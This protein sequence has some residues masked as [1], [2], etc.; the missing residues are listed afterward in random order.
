MSAAAVAGP[1]GPPTLSASVRGLL[2]AL[3]CGDDAMLLRARTRHGVG[4][5]TLRITLPPGVAWIP[6]PL[7]E[8]LEEDRWSITVPIATAE[9]P[10][11]VAA[12]V[13]IIDRPPVYLDG[14]WVFD[15][16]G[17]AAALRVLA[18]FLEPSVLI[19][20][21]GAGVAVWML[22]EPISAR[23]VRVLQLH[24]DVARVTGATALPEGAS[25]EDLAVP[26][27]GSVV[28]ELGGYSGYVD[29]LWLD[30]AARYTVEE[31]E[32]A[33]AARKESARP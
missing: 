21:G 32:A 22:A 2:A 12:V 13:A 27:P 14:R 8:L 26:L 16:P 25:V 6:G 5:R 20:A 33:I 10:A 19:N 28:R 23:D 18:A 15:E 1:A 4:E 3:R 7:L 31:I 11:R 24:R 29:C 30:P 9:T 17:I